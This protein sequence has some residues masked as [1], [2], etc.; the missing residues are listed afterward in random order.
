M[1]LT[2]KIVTV[3]VVAMAVLL[4]VDGYFAIQRDVAHFE[5]MSRLRASFFVHVLR[6]LWNSGT[7]GRREALRLIQRVNG[8]QNLVHFSL[9]DLQDPRLLQWLD[10]R[11]RLSVVRGELVAAYHTD[12]DGN[13]RYFMFALL[14]AEREGGDEPRVG[15]LMSFRP[16][17]YA[18]P[19]LRGVVL[20]ILLMTGLMILLGAMFV[21]F[22]GTEIVGR[23]LNRLIEKTRRIGE[24]DLAE[25][26]VLRGKDEL[27][28]LARALNRMCDQLAQS[29]EKAR[30]EE[31]ARMAAMEQ[32]R[33]ADRLRTVGGLASGMAHELGTPLNVVSGRAGLIA[34]GKLSDEEVRASAQAIK[35]ESQ[36]MATIIRQLLDFARRSTPQRTDVDVWQI[37]RQTI[38]LLDA[39]ARKQ[40]VTLE[41]TGD[42]APVAAHVDAGQI[43]QVLT[44]L[45]VNAIQAMPEGGQVSIGVGA[46]TT[47]PRGSDPSQQ[48]DYVRI[49]VRDE[50]AGIAEEDIEHLFEPFF[51]TKDIGEG[52]GLGLSIAYGIVEEH[53]GW[54][55]VESEPGHGSLFSVY[56]P[57]NPNGDTQ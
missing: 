12:S 43:Q 41:L 39:L 46:V 32:L 47:A 4:A 55:E 36:R 49:D 30:R 19:R 13:Q 16:W 17:P 40:R 27:S 3:L 53:E 21:Y 54:I 33:H 35:A 34:S 29:Q 44:N 25:P 8:E 20:H 37:I 2:A 9:G 42:E 51:T 50:G 18:S 22:L 57:R 24:G 10:A 38:V 11:K 56:L 7:Q 1:R 45:I 48:R 5:E 31:A 52:T 28:E 23:P 14:S 26:L 15:L 6:G